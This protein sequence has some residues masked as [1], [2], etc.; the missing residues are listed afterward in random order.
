M[1]HNVELILA[2]WFASFSY[3]YFKKFE[4]QVSRNFSL[5]FASQKNLS[6][7]QML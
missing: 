4:V 3:M 1:G 5:V 7:D 6:L 2:K